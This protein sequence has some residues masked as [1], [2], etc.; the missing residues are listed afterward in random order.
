LKKGSIVYLAIIKATFYYPKKGGLDE[1]WV[2]GLFSIVVL[3]L[4][5]SM[6]VFSMTNNVK[7]AMQKPFDVN[8]ITKLWKTLASF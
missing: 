1:I 2:L 4:Q 7:L 8:P 6:F 5:R 3:N